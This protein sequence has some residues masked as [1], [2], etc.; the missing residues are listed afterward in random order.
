MTREIGDHHSP[1]YVFSQ[2]G[3]LLYGMRQEGERQRLFSIDLAT[4]RERIIGEVRPA[5]PPASN[6][7]P[8]IRFSLSPD[9]KSVIYG[10][11]TF[12]SNL[13]ILA[14]FKPRRTSFFELTSIRD[15]LSLRTR[16]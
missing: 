3:K 13:W 5:L 15:M 1:H 2:D 7:T 4:D 12:K 16:D 10:S 9:G 6:L 11:G 14:G 8:S